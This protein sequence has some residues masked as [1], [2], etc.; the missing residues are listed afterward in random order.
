V[1]PAT[2]RT[3]PRTPA[4]GI[5]PT[6]RR[7]N[8]SVFVE[9]TLSG[10]SEVIERDLTDEE[11]ASRPGPLQRLDPRA[12]V[13]CSAALILTSGLVAHLPVLLGLYG[14][15]LA[16]GLAAR[17]PASLIVRRVWLVLPFFTFVVALPAMFSLVTPG[18]AAISFGRLG[19]IDLA[20]TIPGLRTALTLV[21]RVATSVSAVLLLV[22]TTR[23]P[24]LLSALRA[25]R[26]P[27]LFVLVLAMTYR[28]IFLLAHVANAMFLARKSRTVGA[29]SGALA[30]RWV[31][32]T[33]STLLGKS[34]HLSSEVYL[35]MLSRGF[36]GEPASPSTARMLARDFVAICEVAA[37]CVGIVLIDRSYGGPW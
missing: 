18:P 28:Y 37:A 10:L 5:T 30:R 1:K 32:G 4:R 26:V 33:A 12:K 20:I 23:W 7:R 17:L 24:D 9:R 27:Q 35:A 2:G 13:V 25:V 8:G 31:G 16:I 15:V 14:V 11:L 6:L 19:D 34:Y 36:R 22:V 3:A 29:T 21:F